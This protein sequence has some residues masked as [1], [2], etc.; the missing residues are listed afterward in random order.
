MARPSIATCLASLAVTL[1]AGPAWAVPVATFDENVFRLRV[2]PGESLSVRIEGRASHWTEPGPAADYFVVGLVEAIGF[3]P[4]C[5]LKAATVNGGQP[6][7]LWCALDPASID[8]APLR[9]RLS[10]ANGNDRASPG[11][12]AFDVRGVVYAGAGDDVV[13]GDRVFGGPGADWL[14]G[15][16]L[17]G[18][19]GDDRLD[20]ADPGHKNVARGGPGDDLIV[21][22]GDVGGINW[23]YGG[24]GND[25]LNASLYTRDM[26]VGGPGHDVVEL[27]M[28]GRPD[29]VRLRGG[30]ADLLRCRDVDGFLPAGERKDIVFADAADRI[31]PDCKGTRVL[32]KGKP[33]LR[34]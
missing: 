16:V 29:L 22:F 19:A 8:S 33:R 31:E 18:G 23:A 5:S 7:Q 11:S 10:F 1:F 9:Y 26:L 32:L 20:T 17:N 27:I 15:P 13:S 14:D 21:T 12:S 28:D 6:L 30:G 24:R 34:R 25:H 3:G 4:G 2:P